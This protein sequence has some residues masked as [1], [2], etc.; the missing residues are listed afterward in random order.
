MKPEILGTWE[1]VLI[2]ASSLPS[3]IH[4]HYDTLRVVT[5]AL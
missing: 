2:V 4:N 1:N 3:T 5:V